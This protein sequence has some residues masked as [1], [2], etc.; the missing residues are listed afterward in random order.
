MKLTLAGPPHFPPINTVSGVMK[1]VLYAL[2]PG[3]AAHVWFF[4]FGILFQIALAVGFALALEPWCEPVTFCEIDPEARKVLTDQF[5]GVPI[6]PDVLDIH[7]RDLPQC[8]VLT[9]GFPCQDLS[10]A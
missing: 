9:A 8:D 6:T 10:I 1:Q 2:V 3:I 5:P 7:G 4:G